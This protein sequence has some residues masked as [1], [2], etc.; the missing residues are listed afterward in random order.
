[1]NG[2][3]MHFYLLAS[4][5]AR[6]VVF[7]VDAVV[8]CLVNYTAYVKG[9]IDNFY[10]KFISSNDSLMKLTNSKQNMQYERCLQKIAHNQFVLQNDY[11]VRFSNTLSLHT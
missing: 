4:Y 7:A 9:A 1:M 10:S 6:K 3:T 11:I 5:L 2:F 8:F